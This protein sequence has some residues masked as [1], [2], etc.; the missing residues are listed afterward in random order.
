MLLFSHQE[1]LFNMAKPSEPNWRKVL[2]EIWILE[3][4]QTFNK[5]VDPIDKDALRIQR[6]TNIGNLEKKKLV[7]RDSDGHVKVTNKGRKQFKVVMAGGAFDIIH[8]G[9]IETLEKAKALGDI[10]VVSVARN[11]TIE[12][13]KGRK[14]VHDEKLRRKLVESIKPVDIAVLGSENDIFETVDLLR[15]DIIA[16]GY[17]QT[18]S[19]EKMQLEVRKRGFDISVV[20]LDSSVPGIKTSK[21]M[22]TNSDL[23]SS[24]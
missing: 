13:S 8:P 2:A 11:A 23:I 16:L 21:I 14:P 19:E 22:A 20:R 17:D 6:L 18:H 4:N 1:A 3:K 7:L 15:P 9:H 5:N 10:L 24:T 12:R